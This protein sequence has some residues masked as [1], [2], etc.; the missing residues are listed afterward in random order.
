MVGKEF[1]LK[2]QNPLM[3]TVAHMKL[4]FLGLFG[5]LGTPLPPPPWGGGREGVV[6]SGKG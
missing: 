5:F 1:L 3:K 6:G 4:F 2:T